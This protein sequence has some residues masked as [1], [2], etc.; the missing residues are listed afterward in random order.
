V[1]DAFDDPYC[2]PGTD[3]LRNKLNLR[4]A[5]A[6]EAF[7]TEIT[8]VRA[9]ESLPSGRLSVAHYRA[10]H[11]HLFQDVYSWAG[12][13]RTVRIAKGGNAFCFPEYIEPEIKRLFGQLRADTWLRNRNP[14]GFV[15]GAT[16]FLTVLNQIHPFREG[17]GRTQLAFLAV[18][19]ER[20]GHKLNF[21]RLD[22]VAT[23]DAMIAS[24]HDEKLPLQQVLAA[25][26]K[27]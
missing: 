17:N 13:F 8:A 1:Y 18:L 15:D 25:M 16:G 6:L 20:A 24:F 5:D 11:R 23:L 19:G 12:D 3:V 22:P 9:S 7:E 4:D 2:Y 21:D 10:I 27:D 26:L 14:T